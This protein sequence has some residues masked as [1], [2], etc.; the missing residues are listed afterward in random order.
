MLPH[1]GIQAAQVRC[2]HCAFIAN[3]YQIWSHKL[4]WS[5][6]ACTK[7]KV[8]LSCSM[9][10]AAAGTASLMW[11]GGA[12]DGL[13]PVMRWSC[14]QVVAHGGR[15]DALHPH[16]R[17][18]PLVDYEND[19]GHGSCTWLRCSEGAGGVGERRQATGASL[20]LPLAI[21]P[22]HVH[23]SRQH[24]MHGDMHA[25]AL[26]CPLRSPAFEQASHAL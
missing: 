7:R 13:P 20:W 9:Q 1:A 3:D 16:D 14:G 4:S 23:S 5:W 21:G 19:G 10:G 11:P 12:T 24:M 15:S 25:H 18:Q 17:P 8:M 6:N 26:S 2:R 22:R